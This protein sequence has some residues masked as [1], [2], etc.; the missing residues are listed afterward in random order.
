[1]SDDRGL[2][3]LLHRA[4]WTRLSMSAEVSG[5][6]T[7]LIAP[8]KRY[9]YQS[10]EYVTGCDGGRPWELSRDDDDPDGSV[11]WIS[12]PEPP[13]RRLLCPAWLL[14]G[15]GLQV[16][17][18]VRACGRDALDVVLTRRPGQRGGPVAAEDPAAQLRVLVDAELG[19]L[20]R[21]AEPGDGGEPRVTELV[22]ADFDPVIDPDRFAPLPGSR[23][24]EGPRR[25]ARPGL[26]GRQD[27]G[28]PGG[29]CSRRVDQVLTVPPRPASRSRWDRFRGGDPAR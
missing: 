7:V 24:A 16:Q 5:G 12:G 6:S 21:I 9:R 4:D 26:V 14:E 8:G 17:G 11:H 22:S 18:R 23:I 10:A 15:S 1:M 2:V 28:G 29:R 3:G 13:L 27:R 19:I 20:L 25:D